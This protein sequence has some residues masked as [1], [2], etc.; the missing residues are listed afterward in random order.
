MTSSKSSATNE[1]NQIRWRLSDI[2]EWLF[3]RTKEDRARIAHIENELS[4][5]KRTVSEL[6]TNQ[7][8]GITAAI[9]TLKRL[10]VEEQAE[11]K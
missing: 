4:E 8:D 2:V 6:R 3:R 11:V 9:D 7:A 5:L 1:L 10:E